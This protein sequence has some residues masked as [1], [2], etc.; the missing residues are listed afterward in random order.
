MDNKLIS[1]L[2]LAI[3]ALGVGSWVILNEED[4]MNKGPYRPFGGKITRKNKFKRI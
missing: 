2:S 1:V 3:L 4:S